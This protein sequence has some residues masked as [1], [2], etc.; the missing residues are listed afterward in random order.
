MRNF[1]KFSKVNFTTF[2]IL[3][4]SNS[5]FFLFFYFKAIFNFFPNA[6]QIILNFQPLNQINQMQGHLCTNMLLI[7]MMNFNLVIFLFFYV[8]MSTK[9]QNYLNLH[10][11]PKEQIL[12]CYNSTLLKINLVPEI[13]KTSTKR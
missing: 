7:L 12:G 4:F 11:F 5:L 8:F 10:L 9:I 6:S 1:D 3:L 13:R 2:Q